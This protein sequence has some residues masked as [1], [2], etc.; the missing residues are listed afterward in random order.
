MLQVTLFLDQ[1]DRVDDKPMHEHILHHLLHHHI[2]GATVFA[3]LGGFGSHR[4]LHYPRRL[5]ASD[6]VPLM[7]VFIDEEERVRSV[8]PH[9]RELLPNG[10]MTVGTVETVK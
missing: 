7:I 6:E 8:L 5:G 9:L 3:G 2:A 10:L 1:D 4:H